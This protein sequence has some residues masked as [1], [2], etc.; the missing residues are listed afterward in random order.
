MSAD[1]KTEQFFELNTP[2]QEIY[3]DHNHKEDTASFNIG[4]Y[5]DIKQSVDFKRLE[6]AIQQSIQQHA[7]LRSQ[8]VESPEK[9]SPCYVI[10]KQDFKL[11]VTDCSQHESPESAANQLIKSVFVQPFDLKTD[12]LY[13]VAL[14]KLSEH[15]FWLYF[16]SHHIV[17]DGA[18]YANWIRSIFSHYQLLSRGTSTEF[19]VQ[20]PLT[21]VNI[22]AEKQQRRQQK[23]QA[24]WKEQLHPLPDVPLQP[25]NQSAE[26][27]TSTKLLHHISVERYKQWIALASE[28]GLPILPL[29]M[30]A[31]SHLIQRTFRSGAFIMGTPLHNRTNAE[32]RDM[33]GSFMSMQPVLIQAES[34]ATVT[35]AV[36]DTARSIKSGFRH[37]HYPLSALYQ[38]LSL[39]TNN[40]ERL[41][42]VVFNYQL[43]DFDFSA[44]GL[45]VESHY[46][47]H[48]HEEMPL[49]ITLCEYG[50]KQSTQLQLDYRHDYFS[51]EQALALLDALVAIIE[52][53]LKQP[54]ALL[55][56][57]SLLDELPASMMMQA[58]ASESFSNVVKRI[59]YIASYS[60]KD[61]AVTDGNQQITY[62]DLNRQ[63]NQLARFLK[64]THQAQA[65]SVI[66]IALPRSIQYVVAMLAVLKT[67]AAYVSLDTDY[68]DQRLNDMLEDSKALCLITNQQQSERNFHNTTALVLTDQ[69]ECVAQYSGFSQENL[70]EVIIAKE[71]LAYLMYTSGSTGKPKGV[72]VEHGQLSDFVSH[73]TQTYQLTSADRFLQFSA[74]SFDIS[75]EECFGSLCNGATLVLRTSDLHL[76]LDAFYEYCQA[77]RISIVSLPTA[78]WHQLAL[79][80]TTLS[81]DDLRLVILGGEALKTHCV[82]SWFESGPAIELVNTY[83]PTETTVTASHHVIRGVEDIRHTMPIGLP[84]PGAQL[85]LLDEFMHPVPDTLIGE[86]CIAG[87]GVSR[88]YL[89]REQETH[90]A[91]IKHPLAQ[92]RCYRTGD[93]ARMTEEGV[94]EFVGRKD[95]QMKLNGFRIEPNEILHQLKQF[96]GI[97]DAILVTEKNANSH[98]RLIAYVVTDKELNILVLRESLRSKLADYMIPAAF[99]SLTKLPLTANGKVNFQQLPE[100]KA[101][102][103]GRQEYVAPEGKA[104]QQ[105]AELWQEL[106]KVEKAGRFDNFF[107]LGG[108]SLLIMTMRSQL[109]QAG[110]ELPLRAIYQMPSL[111]A[112]AAE[113]ISVSTSKQ[114][115]APEIRPSQ[116]LTP[117]MFCLLDFTQEDI[118]MLSSKVEG[119]TENIQDIYPLSP[120]QEGIFFHHQMNEERDT[121]VIPI[122]M[123]FK[124]RKFLDAFITALN[125]VVQRH[126]VFRTSVHW[127][128]LSA[129]VQVVQRKARVKVNWLTQENEI[130]PLTTLQTLASLNNQPLCLQSAPMME[131]TATQCIDSDDCYLLLRQHHLLTDHITVLHQIEEVKALMADVNAELP[132]PVQYREFVAHTLNKNTSQQGHEYF[133]QRLADITESTAP[134]GLMDVYNDAS[135]IDIQDTLLGQSLSADIQSIASTYRISPAA[136]FHLAW[137]LVVAKCSGKD[138]VVFGTMMSGRQQAL[139]GVERI[140]GLLINLLPLRTCLTN[141]SVL[142]AVLAMQ[143]NIIELAEY[144]C[145]PLAEILQHASLPSGTPLFT[146]LINYRHQHEQSV[147][148]EQSD[149]K[150]LEAIEYTNYPLEMGVDQ[151]D[152][153]FRLEV[154]VEK[155]IGADAVLGY[156]KTALAAIIQGLKSDKDQAVLSLSITPLAEQERIVKDFNSDSID[157]EGAQTVHQRFEQQVTLHPTAIAAVCNDQ[158]VTYTELNTNANKLAHY[159]I[160]QGVQRNHIVAIYAERSIEFLTAM[161]GIMKAGAAYVPLDP[162]NPP[163][164]LSYMLSDSAVQVVLSQQGLSGLKFDSQ[165]CFLL[166][167]HWHLLDSFPVSNPAVDSQPDDLSYMIYTSGST[168]KPK[169]ALVHH[170]GALNH[171]DAEFDVLG[172]LTTDGL[173]AR[174]FLQS[175]ASSSDVSVW[176]FLAPLMCGGKT[177]VLQDAMDL[178][179]YIEVLHQEQ[180]H[181]IQTAPSVLKLLMEALIQQEQA[182][183][184]TDLKWLMIIAEPCPVPLVNRWLQFYPDI[185]VMNGYG[186][187]EASD[188]ITYFVMDKPLSESVSNVPVGKPLPNLTMYVLDANLQLLP[189]NVV[190]ELCVSGVGVGKGY[191]NKPEKTEHSFKNNPYQHLG[192][193]G[194]RLYRTGD[195]GY[196]TEEGNLEL[197]GRID[198]QVKVRGFRVELGEVESALVKLKMIAEA[199]VLIHKNQQSEN[200]L[201]A[202][203]VLSKHEQDQVLALR[204]IKQALT[205]LL[206]DYM[207]PTSFLILERMPLNAADKIDR[208]NLP[209]PDFAQHVENIVE[210]QTVTEKQLQI[211]WTDILGLQQVS[212][213]S[214]FFDLGGHS[215][216]A[217]RLVAA[218]RQRLSI[219]IPVRRIFEQNTIQKLATLVDSQQSMT[220]VAS[221]QC[222]P[223]QEGEWLPLSFAQERLW[224]LDQLGNG[225]VEYNM[226]IALQL[227]GH[228]NLDWANQAFAFVLEQHTVLR[229]IYSN[230]N[231]IPHQQVQALN[232]FSIEHFDIRQLPSAEQASLIEQLMEQEANQAFD[233]N[234][235]ILL[236]ARFIQQ[237]DQVGVLLLTTHHIAFDGWS[238]SILATSFVD[239]YRSIAQS[240]SLSIKAVVQYSDYALWQRDWLTGEHLQQQQAYWQEKLANLPPVHDLPLDYERPA[241][242]TSAGAVV[243]FSLSANTSAALRELARQQQTT[244]FMLLHAAFT[245][246]ISRTST[247]KDIVIGTPVANRPQ[248]ELEELIGFFVNTQVLRTECDLEA[249]FI[250]HLAQVRQVNLDAQS[251]Q[252]IPFELLVE[253]LN[254]QRSL[255]YTPLFQI[256]FA[257]DTSDDWQ[258][259]LPDLSIRPIIREHVHSQYELILNADDKQDAINFNFE[260]LTALFKE[261][262]IQKFAQRLIVLLESIVNTPNASLHA[263]TLLPEQEQQRLLPVIDSIADEALTTET[264]AS[265]FEGHVA[266]QPQAIALVDGEQQMSFAQLNARAN[267]LARYLVSRGVAPEQRVALFLPRSMDLIVAIL[268]VH[269]AGAAYVPMAID[270]PAERLDFQLKDS[271]PVLILTHT[272]LSQNF[273]QDSELT[274]LDSLTLKLNTFATDNLDQ[275]VATSS[276]QLAYVIYTSGSTGTPKGVMIEQGSL[277]NLCNGLQSVYGLAPGERM[278]QFAAASFDMSVEE[279]FGALCNGATLV[280]R[281]DDCLSSSEG[282]WNFCSQHALSRLNLPTAFWHQLVE[283]SPQ[284]LPASIGI[285]SVGG[286]A[287]NQARIEQWQGRY[288]HQVK[289]VNAYGPTEA[290]VN[291]C[292]AEYDRHPLQSIG[293]PVA[294]TQVYLMTDHLTLTPFGSVGEIVIGGRGVARGYLNREEL[295]QDRF[296][297][298]PFGAGRLYRT[299]DLARYLAD[300]TLSYIGRK[301]NQVKVR[302]YRVELGEIEAQLIQLE[303]IE[304]AVVITRADASGNQALIAYYTVSQPIEVDRVRRALKKALPDY[305]VPAL[306]CQLSSI[307]LTANRKVDTTALP[308]PQAVMEN[309]ENSAPQSDI[310]IKLAA[311]WQPLL[312]IAHIQREADFFSLGGHSLLIIRLLALIKE[313]FAIELDMI[314]IFENAT[315]IELAHVIETHL[316]QQQIA[317][318]MEESSE[319]GWL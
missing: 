68:P 226:P 136:V 215:L 256:M 224:T 154:H 93:L 249:T 196:W 144:E 141:A 296:I 67:G 212:C 315:L 282:F 261:Q 112:L 79:H 235:D 251:H 96:D 250:E 36:A 306:Y 4:G 109:L 71:Q 210:P 160:E 43:I 64:A 39:R 174:N 237:Q 219:D 124:D 111:S 255:S 83:G 115:A 253:T 29:F 186:P 294:N 10:K 231:G 53:M 104:E 214:S 127:Q 113:M 152:N 169:G 52:K 32:Q 291:A 178:T 130:D 307:P 34:D 228:F 216:T 49:T 262:T 143:K 47:S 145:L 25:N 292:I 87:R 123:Q 58:P 199:A 194:E 202:Y 8:V 11:S 304:E 24:F 12:C 173:Q 207:I 50:E 176:Q 259:T 177:V 117:E 254:P 121:Y 158:S 132:E 78:F 213:T 48:G 269:K 73:C 138:D 108:H 278:L 217:V 63:A 51:A 148:N 222:L 92:G 204:S 229:T 74:L 90:D 125:K 76:D 105:L 106:L 99:V 272:S 54:E 139:A 225:S 86:I 165:Q 118:D 221:I 230:Q 30:T 285:I 162:N 244:L 303:A 157:Y 35:Q 319:E 310:E 114:N 69:S 98:Q 263:L 171:I 168:G 299:G 81:Y 195:L 100:P 281:N 170:A 116:R 248:V 188:D 257:M 26:K 239:A 14:I 266:Q 268:A 203:L 236:R 182:V 17:I 77:Q 220:P 172:F 309:T 147:V 60:P 175:A 61:I 316:L 280:L 153:D 134:F 38:D 131:L 41:F 120:L 102:D 311:L 295:T 33:V 82:E 189:V 318:A 5:V 13:R 46:L 65:E 179:R 312:G 156:M 18:G 94:L 16:I 91:F 88:G 258:L 140:F 97:N 31:I 273:P 317:A 107:E 95:Q 211:I 37:R 193:H 197:V 84:N 275:E 72:M 1:K 164:R 243:N 264:S 167:A 181:L 161:L 159:L 208:H 313:H 110:Y 128:Q 271:Q 270:A 21:T 288:Q 163:E 290:T 301:D 85:L 126:D 56:Q 59:E 252:D 129:P 279:I 19:K 284:Q 286:E 57:F 185:P 192:G 300:G 205:Q 206:P 184:L 3:L 119:G 6:Q 233:L 238:E 20:W 242:T 297:E 133:R 223:K 135:Q 27:N 201:V 276:C 302:G 137:A 293:E 283:E 23:A 183:P 218:I 15:R 62:A 308:A 209:E 122:L 277:V 247:Q 190:G 241:Y 232:E 142:D 2:Q 298:N 40:R 289:L 70:K 42:D 227:Q 66:A 75:I 245:I 180:V 274:C 191:W 187:S 200:V 9:A 246:L 151:L 101:Q 198:N 150:L 155:R 267:Q 89:G 260:Y 44:T 22:D 149:F 166:D 55:S 45:D 314:T 265:M 240:E 103:F 234:T 287:L 28:A 305:M 80:D 146:S 7:V